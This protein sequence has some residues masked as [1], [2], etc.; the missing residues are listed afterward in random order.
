MLRSEASLSIIDEW[1]GKTCEYYIQSDDALVPLISNAFDAMSEFNKTSNP[2]NIQKMLKTLDFELSLYRRAE[3]VKN[4]SF[5]SLVFGIM[6]SLHLTLSN[7]ILPMSS[8]SSSP[9]P[10]DQTRDVS[11]PISIDNQISMYSPSFTIEP[12]DQTM[13]MTEPIPIDNQGFVGS[14]FIKQEEML[15][16]DVLSRSNDST[17][18][19]I[20]HHGWSMVDDD[21]MLDELSDRTEAMC[22][23][24]SIS[25]EQIEEL[26][27][28]AKSFNSRRIEFGLTQKGAASAVGAKYNT[29][30]SQCVIHRFESLSLTFTG[31][32]KYGPLI[33]EWLEETEAAIANGATPADLFKSSSPPAKEKRNEQVLASLP[34][35]QKDERVVMTEPMRVPDEAE[36]D[37]MGN[38]FD[39]NQKEHLNDEFD[40]NPRPNYHRLGEI[41]T[42]V[43]L[44]RDVVR[45]WFESRRKQLLKQEE[46]KQK[47]RKAGGGD[48]VSPPAN[49]SVVTKCD[50]FMEDSDGELEPVVKKPKVDPMTKKPKAESVVKKLKEDK[51]MKKPRAESLVRKVKK[52]EK[53]AHATP[54]S[55]KKSASTPQCILCEAHPTT[56]YGYAMHLHNCHKTTLMT[57]GIYLLC[58]CG[59]E[60]HTRAN[61]VDHAEGKC[62][63]HKFTLH[64][65]EN[66]IPVPNRIKKRTESLL[67]LKK[68]ILHKPDTT[69]NVPNRIKKRTESVLALDK[70]VKKTLLTSASKPIKKTLLTSI[71]KLF[72]KGQSSP[73]CLMCEKFPTTIN[74][75]RNHLYQKHQ[76]NLKPLGFYLLCSCGTEVHNTQYNPNHTNKTCDG[77]KFILQ[78]LKKK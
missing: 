42:M 77:L 28:V 4:L 57:N 76:S 5:R 50:V 23:E 63:G 71:S 72:K 74:G 69:K 38:F 39:D 59:K 8:P 52:L 26:K 64:Q 2:S 1:K 10:N 43:D 60:Y 75:Y 19:A 66:T 9:E 40:K 22:Y 48:A 45:L 65:L 61:D 35:A 53:K 20:N 44:D 49:A 24:T 11:E 46:E 54:S 12:N 16:N 3:N 58:S 68:F 27:K 73:K 32:C 37:E 55:E 18:T 29:N 67:A 56:A 14:R 31:M 33:K 17:L 78:K 47:E 34:P 13:D 21:D 25:Q 7:V 30:V 6:E 36:M 62:D 51:V 41:A 70:L 15:N